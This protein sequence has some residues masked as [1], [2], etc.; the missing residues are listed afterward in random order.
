MSTNALQRAVDEFLE[1]SRQQWWLR[2]VAVMAAAAAMLA[3]VAANGSWPFGLVAVMVLSA[4]SAL[5]PDT[6]VALVVVVVVGW[7]WLATVEE[8]GTPWLPVAAIC[9]LVFHTVTALSATVP[10]GGELPAALIGRW[11]RRTT[12]VACATVAIW[13]VVVLFERRDAPGNAVLTGLALTVLAGCAVAIWSRSV[14][15]AP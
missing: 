5:R 1:T 15:R 6:N 3:A 13:I 9:L 4:V 2:A 11:A 8:V 10:T 14:E 12:A 7:H